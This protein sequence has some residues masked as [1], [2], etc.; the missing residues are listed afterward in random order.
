MTPAHKVKLQGSNFSEKPPFTIG[1]WGP[2]GMA[3]GSKGTGQGWLGATG[4][5]D[6]NA[7]FNGTIGGQHPTHL[8]SPGEGWPSP[9]EGNTKRWR[10]RQWERE[11]RGTQGGE[12]PTLL[13]E[14]YTYHGGDTMHRLHNL[15]LDNPQ[16]MQILRS[17]IAP[18]ALHCENR[19]TVPGTGAQQPGCAF[20][21]LC[22]IIWLVLRQC[23]QRVLRPGRRKRKGKGPHDPK[24]G[25]PG[26]HLGNTPRVRPS[27][28]GVS[29]TS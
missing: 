14:G 9:G 18:G 2:D 8:Q 10:E 3:G 13:R 28:R 15:Q 24:G 12:P 1:G 7:E 23:C 17:E 25:K 16:C 11:R 20:L 22:G 5:L 29:R 19:N 26:P 4:I 21:L 6:C 27:Q